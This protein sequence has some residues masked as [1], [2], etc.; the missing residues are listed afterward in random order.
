[1][2]TEH[3][4][5]RRIAGVLPPDSLFAV[6]GRV[7]DELRGEL[8]NIEVPSKDL[9]YV[10][11]GVSF[12][13]LESALARLGRVDLVGASFAV[14]KLTVDGETVD[15]ALPRRERSVGVGHRD[16][17]VASGPAVRL[18]EDLARRDFRMN[19]IARGVPSGALID[20]YGGQADIRARRIDVLTAATFKEDPL[21][22]LRAAQFAARFA[23]GVSDAARAAMTEAAPLARSVSG[24]RIAEELTKLFVR[25]ERPSTGLELLR[26]T[27]VL[28][29]LWP[30]MLEGYG[31]AQ[32]E[33]HAFDVYRHNLATLDAAPAG[34]LI[35]RLAAL[36]HDVGKPRV[37]DGP[38]FYRHEHVGGDM[39]REMLGRFR[40]SNEVIET[41]EHLVRQHMYNQ[42][43]GLSDAAVRRFVRRVGV[44]RLALQFG[45]RH[46]D[47][48]G[49]GMPK[50][51]DS[52]ERFESR[53]WAEVARKPPFSI[54]DLRIDGDAILST[55]IRTGLAA[56]GF[57]GDKRVGDALAHL[58]EQVTDAPERNEPSTLQ[59]LLEQYLDALR[60]AGRA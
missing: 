9:D 24:E 42:D 26:E 45:L 41:T 13:N 60:G 32:N 6:G 2:F 14:I 15:V 55:M 56:P 39:V 18:D 8:D 36:L 31:V 30:E 46:A 12:A 59:T 5:D 40:F 52:N 48:E 51:D 38:H 19:M 44:D 33:W 21:R 16:F 53:V 17:D 54:A 35:L 34:D 29:H 57:R 43:P 3:P 28:A 11:V 7:R 22:L 27:G 4:L 23:Y 50:R 58:F 10:V 49:S 37:K 1:M 47:V 20:P 25:A